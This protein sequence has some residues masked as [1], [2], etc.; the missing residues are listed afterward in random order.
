MYD[1]RVFLELLLE[2][3]PRVMRAI[4]RLKERDERGM[5][6][7]SPGEAAEEV[8]SRETRDRTLL[9]LLYLIQNENATVAF[10]MDDPVYMD[11][12]EAAFF[13]RHMERKECGWFAYADLLP[14]HAKKA[15]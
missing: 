14:A 12:D 11:A 15:A 13:I 6:I 2:R 10:L 3:H 8:F 4:A 5:F 1:L 9:C 7:I